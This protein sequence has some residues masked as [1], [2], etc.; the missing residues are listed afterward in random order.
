MNIIDRFIQKILY[1]LRIASKPF[2]GRSGL[3][4]P[5]KDSKPSKGILKPSVA[6]LVGH[7]RSGDNGAMT[8][9]SSTSEWDYNS[10]IAKRTQKILEDFPIKTSVFNKYK[11]NSYA[12]AILELSKDL[13]KLEYDLVIELH[14][15]S[16][17]NPQASGYENI[18]WHSSK[19][20]KKAA[21]ELQK[22]FKSFFPKSHKDRKIKAISH[23]SQ[24]GGML[25]KHTEAPSVICE[26][27]FGSNK[28]EWKFFKSTKGRNKLS[29]AYAKAITSILIPTP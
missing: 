1:S 2:G 15:N 14:F 22:S 24:R 16:F 20:G 21:E 29:K 7:S 23:S 3:S 8:L 17:Y 10:D 5:K 28:S 9:D 6:I 11:G 26:P 18:Y 25:L 13:N 19:K 27:F 4:T 12:Q